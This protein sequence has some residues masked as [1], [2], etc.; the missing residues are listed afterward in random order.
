MGDDVR[1]AFVFMQGADAAG[2]YEVI[3]VFRQD[4]RHS[5]MTFTTGDISLFGEVLDSSE[6]DAIGRRAILPAQ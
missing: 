1:S 3:W 4:G 2:T 5:R 6:S